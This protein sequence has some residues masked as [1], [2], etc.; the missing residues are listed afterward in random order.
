MRLIPNFQ[1]LLLK[2]QL[3]TLFRDWWIV[4]EEDRTQFP[5]HPFD[6][7]GENCWDESDMQTFL[8]RIKRQSG[9]FRKKNTP[10]EVRLQQCFLQ[11]FPEALLLRTCN[12]HRHLRDRRAVMEVLEHWQKRLTLLSRLRSKSLNSCATTTTCLKS[13]L[14]RAL[15]RRWCHDWT[16]ISVSRLPDAWQSP[17]SRRWTAVP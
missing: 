14:L 5:N 6:T 10:E 7:Y 8:T 1:D 2:D 13:C 9:F 17:A 11:Q 3:P 12:L 15:P 16:C 4:E